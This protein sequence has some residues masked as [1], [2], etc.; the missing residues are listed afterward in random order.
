MNFSHFDLESEVSSLV[1]FKVYC[2]S[3]KCVYKELTGVVLIS[4]KISG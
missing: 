4:T 2:M 3:N 1:D